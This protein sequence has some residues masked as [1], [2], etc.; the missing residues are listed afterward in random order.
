MTRSAD[1]P[2]SQQRATETSFAEGEVTSAE[3]AG[4]EVEK[5]DDAQDNHDGLT[6]CQ[7]LRQVGSSFK[8]PSSLHSMSNVMIEK[9]VMLVLDCMSSSNVMLDVLTKPYDHT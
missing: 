7:L 1:C 9:N 4:R 5:E 8:V 2:P 6:G 3:D